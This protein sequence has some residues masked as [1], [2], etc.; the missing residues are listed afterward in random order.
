[1]LSLAT[2]EGPLWSL[3]K[4]ENIY[5]LI[6]FATHLQ[7]SNLHESPQSLTRGDNSTQTV[8]GVGNAHSRATYLNLCV[9]GEC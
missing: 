6:G 7:F 1:M 2:L 8:C 5:S 9:V 3:N 4:K